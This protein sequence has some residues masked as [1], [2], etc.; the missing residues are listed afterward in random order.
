MDLRL[1]G[2]LVTLFFS[3]TAFALLIYYSATSGRVQK[4]PPEA[5]AGK[6]IF[7]KKACVECHTILGN[8]AYSGGDLTKIYGTLGSEALKDYL[9]HPPLLTGAKNKRHDQLTEEEADSITAYFQFL[10]SINTTEW[11]PRPAH[12]LRE[13]KP[14]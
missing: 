8:G 5:V 11:P 1:K 10:E 3:L 4:M 13:N 14:F 7:Q 9:T 2:F 6:A 12:D